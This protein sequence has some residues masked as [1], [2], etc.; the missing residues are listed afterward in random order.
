MATEV[1]QKLIAR[2]QLHDERHLVL[3]QSILDVNSKLTYVGGVLI[4]MILGVL[5]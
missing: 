2:E 5:G 3:Q 4:A 1:A